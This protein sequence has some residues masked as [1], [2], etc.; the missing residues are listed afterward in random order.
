MARMIYMNS[1]RSVEYDSGDVPDDSAGGL[2]GRFDEQEGSADGSS[3]TLDGP[4][5]SVYIDLHESDPYQKGIQKKRQ[6][7]SN[8][9]DA[10][11]A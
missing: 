4:L 11:E 9:Q 8:G 2:D 6:I 1:Q 5:R 10:Q 7:T 3:A